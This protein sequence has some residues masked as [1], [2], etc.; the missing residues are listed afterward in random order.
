MQQVNVRVSML[1][2]GYSA[3]MLATLPSRSHQYL[4]Q[5]VKAK[6]KKGNTHFG[7]K[8]REPKSVVGWAPAYHLIRQERADSQSKGTGFE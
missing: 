2:V 6:K 4:Q 3:V 7:K 8:P 5:T 1:G